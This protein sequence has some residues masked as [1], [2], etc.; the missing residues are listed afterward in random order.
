MW[1]MGLS[2]LA[3]TSAAL[4]I[5]AESKGARTQVYLFKP[6]TTLLILLIPLIAR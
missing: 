3:L 2:V 1:T 5:R 4:T 6:V